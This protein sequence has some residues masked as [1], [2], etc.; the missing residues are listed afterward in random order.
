[1]ATAPVLGHTPSMTDDIPAAPAPSALQRASDCRLGAGLLFLDPRFWRGDVSLQAAAPACVVI[2]V[3][4][5][6]SILGVAHALR[7]G[8]PWDWG[9]S[10][11]ALAEGRWYALVSHMFAH[12]G[13]MHLFLNSTFLL[14]VTPVVMARFGVGPSGWLRF[15]ILFLVSGLL[16]AGLYLALHFDSAVPMVGAS[17]AI[18]G[19]W[20]AASRL[21]PEGEIVPILSEPVRVQVK[22]FAKMNL[23][24]FAILFVLVRTSG[25][26]GGLAW[27]A[28]LGGFLFGLF[29]MPWLAPPTPAS[30][31]P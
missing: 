23:I 6:A 18:C 26:V 16:G 11:Q 28:H 9:L 3:C 5:A 14:G 21:G 13:G 15:A 10:A 7:G 4:V 27:E 12:A 1:M 2:A 19:V 22:A 31:H 25:G 20:G 24:L 17:G 8:V 30:A 29:A